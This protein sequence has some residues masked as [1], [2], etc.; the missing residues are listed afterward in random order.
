[1]WEF[2]IYTFK[3]LRNTG[4]EIMVHQTETNLDTSTDLAGQ[5]WKLAS[6]AE[7]ADSYDYSIQSFYI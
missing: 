6:Y 2:G 4:E 5:T 1:M 7:H 3:C